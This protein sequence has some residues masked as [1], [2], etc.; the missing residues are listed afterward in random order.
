MDHLINNVYIVDGTGTEPYPGSVLISG[1]KI[2]RVSKDPGL[3]LPE[4]RG[5][6][7]IDGRGRFLTPGFIDVHRHAD[8]RVLSDSFGEIELRQGLTTIINGNCGLSIVP[9]PEGRK[10]EIFEFLS[11]VIGVPEG[12]TDFTDFK[13]Y[14]DCVSDTLPLNVGMLI[15]NGTARSAAAGYRPGILTDDEMSRVHGYLEEALADGAFGVSIGLQYAPEYNYDT[16]ELIRALAPMSGYDA[17]LCTHTRGDGDELFESL[18]EVITVANALHVQL[19]VSH[20]KN[21]GRKNWGERTMRAL[22]VLDDARS[23]GLN[24]NTDV[25]P[26]TYGSTQLIQIMPT[27]LLDGGF[28]AAAKRL[29]DPAVRRDLAVLFRDG[30]P[31]FQN[32]VG[33]LGWE[34]ITLTS[35]ATKEN[36]RYTGLSVPEIA[37][38]RGSEPLDCVCDLLAE[39][40]CRIGMIDYL[41]SEEDVRT[42]MNYGHAF[43]ISDSTYPSTGKPHPRVYGTFARILSEYVRDAKVMSIAAAVNKMTGMPAQ[44]F[45]IDGKGFIKEGFDADLC[46]FDLSNIRTDATPADPAALS[47]G[48]DYVFVGGE[49][50]VIDDALTGTLKGRKLFRRG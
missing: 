25:Y 40:N 50:A 32:M 17:P 35:F 15:G 39:E 36:A 12:E 7:V 23:A 38:L 11:P 3:T 24:V 4:G 13:N 5:L 49:P 8:A 43:F 45:G 29:S 16:K 42:I 1:G 46:V 31:G 2:A 47:K 27:K 19:Q 41:A 21:M 34:N 22:K 28:D 18:D 20:F 14:M 6:T 48:F 37:K 10:K 30:A 44:V 33:L 26:Y 9:C